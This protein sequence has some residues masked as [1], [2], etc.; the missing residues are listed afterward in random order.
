MNKN[1]YL[2]LTLLEQL[3]ELDDEE[4][5]FHNALINGKTIFIDSLNTCKYYAKI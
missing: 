2:D 1:K 4:L 5:A 3:D